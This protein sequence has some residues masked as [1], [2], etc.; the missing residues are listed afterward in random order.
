MAI[1]FPSIEIPEGSAITSAYLTFDVDEV[2][3]CQTTVGGQTCTQTL[4]DGS[5]VTGEEAAV[6]LWIQAS[7]EDDAA[8]ICPQGVN[9][10]A[11]GRAP[12]GSIV[13][14]P[15]T[16]EAEAAAAAAAAAVASRSHPAGCL[17]RSPAGQFVAL[18]ALL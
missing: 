1:R 18:V 8:P 17:A 5:V 12:Q 3:A 16:S 11:D 10:C 2:D 14:R 15:R 4:D 13:D 7:A 6:T 9:G